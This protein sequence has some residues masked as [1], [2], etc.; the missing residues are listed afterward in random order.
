MPT[1]AQTVEARV[2]ILEYRADKQEE[3]QDA[4]R[5]EY[6]EEHTALRKSLQGIEKNLQTIKWVACG[7]GLAFLSQ[8]IG[9]KEAFAALKVFL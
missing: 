9:L 7:A 3:A 4:L 6:T 5:K 2:T 1:E 8:V